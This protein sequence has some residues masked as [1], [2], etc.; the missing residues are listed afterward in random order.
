MHFSRTSGEPLVQNVP[1]FSLKLGAAY[2]NLGAALCNSGHYMKAAQR[3]LHS[4]RPRSAIRWARGTGQ[5]SRRR[6]SKCQSWRSA[7]RWSS[8]RQ[9][10]ND[11]E[12]KALSA[13]VLRGA[14]RCV[15]Q[16]HAGHGAAWGARRLGGGASLGSGAQGGGQAL[17][18]VCG[19]V[20]CPGGES[21]VCRHR[22]QVPQR[23]R[24]HVDGKSASCA[25]L[26]QGKVASQS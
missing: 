7:P 4:S 10:W 14:E 2:Y 13:R 24:G 23:G 8:R 16:H 5:R 26:G 17:R 25:C 19:A 15:S 22:G 20:R 6:P 1:Y 3:Y 12:L 9:W 21:R 11:E 18:A